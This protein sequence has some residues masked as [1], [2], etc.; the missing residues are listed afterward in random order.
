MTPLAKALLALFL[1]HATPP[2]KSV[3]SFEPVP[4]CGKDPAHAACVLAPVCSEPSPL[5][6]PPRWSK[7]RE[8]WVRVESRETAIKRWA[9]IATS[10][11]KTASFLVTCRDERGSVSEDCKPVDWRGKSGS[12]ARLAATAAIF[13]SGLREDVQMGMG[14]VGIGADGERC[15]LQILPSQVRPF[16][17]WIPEEAKKSMTDAQI[18]DTLL[19][20]GVALD[21]CFEVGMRMLVRARRSCAGK[22]VDWAFGSFSMYGTGTTCAAYGIQDDFAL[23]RTKLFRSMEANHD[24]VKLDPAIERLLGLVPAD[25]N[26]QAISQR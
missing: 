23:K 24:A 1:Q 5:C 8:A 20:D 15:M 16:A 21:R 19:G 10:L 11:A 4:G 9:G 14:P 6:A 2:G 25:E 17:T 26:A 7:A 18:A 12:L 3:Y 13:E 22:G